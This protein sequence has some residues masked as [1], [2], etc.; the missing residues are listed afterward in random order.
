MMLKSMEIKCNES[1]LTQ[2]Q[3][4]NQIGFSDSTIKRYRDDIN[5]NS[6]YNGQKKTTITQI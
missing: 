6:P 3:I 2:K 4:S 5:M 1:K